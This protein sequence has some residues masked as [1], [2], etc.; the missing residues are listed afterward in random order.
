MRS[1]NGAIRVRGYDLND[2]PNPLTPT[3]S[4]RERERAVIAETSNRFI[5]VIASAAKQ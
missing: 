3:L 1:I 2:R 5:Y 4:P